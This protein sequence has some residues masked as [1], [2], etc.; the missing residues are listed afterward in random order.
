MA[1]IALFSTL[2]AVAALASLAT[3]TPVSVTTPVATAT[4]AATPDITDVPAAF[5][6]VTK[7][8]LGWPKVLFDNYPDKPM[9]SVYIDNEY[10]SRAEQFY[11]RPFGDGY[12]IRHNEY[13]CSLGVSEYN[14]FCMIGRDKTCKWY[15]EPNGDGTYQIKGSDGSEM[16]ALADPNNEDWISYDVPRGTTNQMWSFELS[17]RP[18]PT[19]V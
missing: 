15:L 13:E 19:D 18:I 5:K 14:I 10:G 2:A 8:G 6:L 11:L 16:T 17:V 3:A 12:E 7:S 4:E 9:L 1:R